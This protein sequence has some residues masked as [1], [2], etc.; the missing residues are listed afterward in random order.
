MF[1]GNAVDIAMQAMLRRS[2]LEANR[3]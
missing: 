1:M 3:D 2:G